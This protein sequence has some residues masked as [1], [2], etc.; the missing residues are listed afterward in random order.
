MSSGLIFLASLLL[1]QLS[2]FPLEISA[3]LLVF[4][5]M[6]VGLTII[7]WGRGLTHQELQMT[8]SHF[9]LTA[10]FI[11]GIFIWILSFLTNFSLPLLIV[12]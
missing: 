9:A 4:P 5:G 8:S 10:T 6:L 3:H 11:P 12:V 1:K 7:V 2:T